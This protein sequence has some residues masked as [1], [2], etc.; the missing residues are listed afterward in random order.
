M[1]ENKKPPASDEAGGEVAL[2]LFAEHF[3][4]AARTSPSGRDAKANRGAARF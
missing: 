1:L 2:D 3:F 4:T